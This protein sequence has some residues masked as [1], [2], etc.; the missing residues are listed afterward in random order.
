MIFQAFIFHLKAQ[1]T[2]NEKK[3]TIFEIFKLLIQA[4]VGFNNLSTAENTRIKMESF[5]CPLC[6]H[7]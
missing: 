7:H 3:E 2:F 4:L 1:K 5:H 6:L